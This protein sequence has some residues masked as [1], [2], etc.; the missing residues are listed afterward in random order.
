[1]KTK[2]NHENRQG[3][4][5][6]LDFPLLFV[7]FPSYSESVVLF[8]FGFPSLRFSASGYLD[9]SLT[10]LG[11]RVLPGLPLPGPEEGSTSASGATVVQP[12]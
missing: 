8:H 6:S 11:F 5:G 7:G 3:P 4:W 12:S 1:M 9:S 10:V 2:E